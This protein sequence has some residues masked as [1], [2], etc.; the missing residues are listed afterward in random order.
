MSDEFRATLRQHYRMTSKSLLVL[1]EDYTGDIGPGDTIGVEV[2]G[3]PKKVTV[4]DLAWGSAMNA[5]RLPLSL[6][7][8]GIGDEEPQP[9]AAIRTW[10][11]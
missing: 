8:S 3:V 1:N 6:V 9:G 11:D 5:E 4:H 10:T 7:V 2:S